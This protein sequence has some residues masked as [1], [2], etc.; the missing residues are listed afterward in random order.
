M[1]QTQPQQKSY[2]KIIGIIVLLLIAGGCLFLFTQHRKNLVRPSNPN[3]QTNSN[4]NKVS[5]A[6]SNS[7]LPAS[8]KL[9]VPFTP[10]APT[11]NWDELHNEACE[12]ASMIMANAYFEH[13]SSLPPA[14]V[15]KEITQLTKWQQDNYGYNLSITTEEAARMAREVFGLKTEVVPLTENTI[16]QALVAGK[17]VVY[18]ANGQLL[19]NPNFKQPGPIYHMLVITGYNK[20]TFI[21]NDPGT[22]NGHDYKYSYDTLETAG[23]TWNHDRHEVD[24]SDK[25]IILISK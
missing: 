23:G 11:A 8:A 17:V 12:E 22:R 13:I 20:D 19:S 6:N 5:N 16:K 2:S 9:E 25:Q 24:T 4:T 1:P 7:A 18:P 14:T 21:T 10:Q 3:T 15:E